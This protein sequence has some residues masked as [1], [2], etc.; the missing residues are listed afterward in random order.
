MKRY[1]LSIGLILA[2]LSGFGQGITVGGHVN[3]YSKS[4]LQTAGQAI[5]NAA[6]VT[7]FM[8]LTNNS[9]T[10]P[11]I[12][13]VRSNVVAIDSSTN[14]GTNQKF[15]NTY[16]AYKFKTASS[17]TIQSF[18]V[19]AKVKDGIISNGIGYWEMWI[20]NDNSG[21]PGTKIGSIQEYARY[22]YLNTIYKEIKTQTDL[23]TLTEN[24]TYWVVLKQ[25]T[26]PANDTVYLDTKNT[27]VSN[28]AYSAN[29]SAWT[30]TNGASLKFILYSP[31]YPALKITAK[32]HY[33]IET[34][35]ET[36]YGIYAQSTW[37]AGANLVSINHTGGNMVSTWGIG[38]RGV[39]THN[40]GLRGE[41]TNYF[42]GYFISTNDLGLYTQTSANNP[43]SAALQA[44]NYGDGFGGI[45]RADSNY[46]IHATSVLEDGVYG[47]TTTAGKAGVRGVSALGYGIKGASTSSY[48]G[49]FTS[50]SGYASYH[51]SITGTPIYAFTYPTSTNT[52]ISLMK[53]SRGVNGTA[54]AGQGGSIDYYLQTS[55]GAERLSGKIITTLTTVT[56]TAEN[57]NVKI[58]TIN[59]GALVDRTVIGNK[60]LTDGS[61]TGVCTIALPTLAMCGG[62]VE[63]TVTATEGA[64]MQAVSGIV[65]FQYVN[66][67]ASYT[68]TIELAS[69]AEDDAVSAGTLTGAW[70]VTTGTNLITINANYD[71]SLTTPTIILYYTIKNNSKNALTIL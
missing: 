70:T 16:Q 54:A 6:N 20:H 31:S 60:V 32:N 26:A 19:F 59:S 8:S 43:N 42:G 65:K 2:C 49:Q 3:A 68:G 39:S 34:I 15:S 40:T 10:T 33:G 38:G 24:T 47:T 69:T 13:M 18:S 44:I 64:D 4:Q 30:V 46:A 57:G 53:L 25:N 61:A 23:I 35:S 63:Y 50:S 12:S 55:T 71:S 21:N 62:T 56:N 48:G 1:I 9:A 27:G 52:S 58:A 36:E 51:Y 67:S 28:Y 37:D 22:G 45:F 17:V 66:K 11:N 7:G 14:T 5:L 41:S 29:G